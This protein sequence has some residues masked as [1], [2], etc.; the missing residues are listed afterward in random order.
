MN[1]KTTTHKPRRKTIIRDRIVGVRLSDE[2]FLRLAEAVPPLRRSDALR[3]G[4][5]LV[6]AEI[7]A[8]K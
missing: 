2:E 1:N 5:V 4:L 7:A 6:L 8:Q 3:R